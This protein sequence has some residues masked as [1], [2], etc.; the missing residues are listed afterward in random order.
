L[1]LAARLWGWE[2]HPGQREFLTLRLPDG[3]EPHTLVAAC[4][5]RWGKTEALGCD[6]ATRILT[7][8]DLGQMG[9]APTRDQAEGLYDSVED[10]LRE[11][12]DGGFEAEDENARRAAQVAILREFPHLAELEFKRSPYP[13]IRNKKTG[14]MVFWVRASG[15]KG[16]NLRGRG[17]TRKLK[18]FRVIVDER[19]FVDDEAV[20]QA[21]KPML[22]TSPGGGQLVEISSPYGKRGGFYQDF[23][24]GERLFK[25]YRSVHLPSSQNPL[26]DAEFLT[27]QRETMSDAAYRTEY[28]AEFLDSAGA[29]FLAGD[30]AAALCGDDYGTAPLWGCRYVAGLDL[31][32]RGDWTVLTV[33]EVGP[34]RL[35]V[36]ELFRVQGLGY[37]AQLE[38]VIEVLRRWGCLR[39][40]ADRTGVGDAVVETLATMIAVA[41]LRCEVDDFI[42]SGPS[43]DVL[44]DA[45]VIALAKL[46]LVF[47][48]HP[49]LLSELQNFESIFVPGHREKLQAVTGHDDCV[50]SLALAV[51][52]AAPFFAG[53]RGSSGAGISVATSRRKKAGDDGWDFSATYGR[54]WA[55]SLPLGGLPR[56]VSW[57]ISET[58]TLARRLLASVY[59]FGPFRSLGALPGSSTRSTPR[60]TRRAG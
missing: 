41:R 30:V 18:R 49:I 27:E 39:I 12:I 17:T 22:A 42:F 11:I 58:K 7:E 32:R 24:K 38:K 45:V 9:V 43:K 10:K 47:P 2:P 33:L 23:L 48:P 4:G 52:A 28:L 37:N 31:A 54:A 59:R 19:A 5:R 16:R 26:V 8:P 55:P 14:Q 44:I 34:D 15:R 51:H 21:I 57:A 1:A 29:V 35:R 60:S 13:L 56:L 6:V 40:A 25:R 3:S 46:Q 20:E 50:C 36:V 53:A